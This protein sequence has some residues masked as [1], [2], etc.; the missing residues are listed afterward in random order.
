[1]HWG[2]GLGMSSA[3][4]TPQLAVC[5]PSSQIVRVGKL[6]LYYKGN[7]D[8]ER[9]KQKYSPQSPAM[10]PY[11]CARDS[12]W[13]HWY[14]VFNICPHVSRSSLRKIRFPKAVDCIVGSRQT[15]G[16]K[17]PDYVDIVEV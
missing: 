3:A 15:M 6:C 16:H 7:L 14:V 13:M 12:G 11:T 1:M 8:S 5:F 2:H 17:M 9:A 4:S 10:N